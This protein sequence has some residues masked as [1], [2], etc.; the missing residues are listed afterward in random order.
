MWKG[1]EENKYSE[2]SKK[3][4]NFL[5]PLKF[6][7]LNDAVLFE[8]VLAEEDKHLLLLREV[9]DQAVGSIISSG[10]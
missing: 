9:R 10:I 1:K 8:W 6:T 3:S 7:D 4:D 5:I 2:I